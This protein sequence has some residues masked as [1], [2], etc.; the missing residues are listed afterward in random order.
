LN[1]SFGI[2]FSSF[3]VE[4]LVLSFAPASVRPD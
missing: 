3:E 2:N 4:V 1:D